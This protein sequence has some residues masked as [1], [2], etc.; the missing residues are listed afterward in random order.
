MTWHQTKEQSLFL[1]SLLSIMLLLCWLFV[2]FSAQHIVCNKIVFILKGRHLIQVYC[3]SKLK[4]RAQEHNLRGICSQMYVNRLVLHG[5]Y[6]LS[7]KSKWKETGPVVDYDPWVC[8]RSFFVDCQ[9][10]VRTVHISPLSLVRDVQLF[11]QDSYLC[12]LF[13]YL[14]Y[15]L[16][17][18]FTWDMFLVIEL[19]TIFLSTMPYLCSVWKPA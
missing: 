5:F 13:Y 2:F 16:L 6:R 7:Y 15:E 12:T 9:N 8:L 10:H 3:F 4:Q 1:H 18:G 19:N 11:W 14:R 17:N